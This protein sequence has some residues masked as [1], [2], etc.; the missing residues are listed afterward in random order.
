MTKA[1]TRI[2]KQPSTSDRNEQLRY[3]RYYEHDGAL[4]A[5]ANRT[6]VLAVVT[7][8]ALILSLGYAIY[9]RQKPPL[10]IRVDQNGVA[11]IA[12][13]SIVTAAAATA[14]NA[15]PTDLEKRAFIHLFLSRYL[16]F[17]ATDVSRNWADALNMMTKN[18]RD[19]AIQ[20]MQKDNLV[21][22]IEDE[23]TRSEFEF[24]SLEVS[25]T[26]ALTFSAFGTRRIHHLKD[27]VETVD[28]LV[29]R[30]QIRLA[31]QPRTEANPS[32]LLI[33]E[34]SEKPIEGEIQNPILN[35]DQVDSRK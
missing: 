4:R 11:S 7:T 32:G 5:Y 19:I 20:H 1:T 12:G 16:N 24:R 29:S 2:E 26:R 14:E 31:V 10:V 6:L 9:L 21:G 17:T 13:K 22:K 35:A 18:L 3:S 25:D 23:N 30:F 8:T 27:G 34:F 28:K 15:E 33:A